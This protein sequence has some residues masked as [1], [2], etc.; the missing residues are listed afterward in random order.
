M[1]QTLIFLLQ[2]HFGTD[3]SLGS[4]L[5]P[6]DVMGAIALDEVAK[7]SV[8]VEGQIVDKVT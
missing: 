5:D 2:S 6:A 3:W 4:H 8:K 7:Q 1:I